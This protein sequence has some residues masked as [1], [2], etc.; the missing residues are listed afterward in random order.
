MILAVKQSQAAKLFESVLHCEPNNAD[1]LRHRALLLDKVPEF[2]HA[3]LKAGFL[4]RL[5][6]NMHMQIAGIGGHRRRP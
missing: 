6:P 4:K 1:A 2:V 5:Q 3:I